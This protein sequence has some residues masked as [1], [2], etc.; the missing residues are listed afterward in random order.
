[1]E[2]ARKPRVSRLQEAVL[3]HETA[4]SLWPGAALLTPVRRPAPPRGG[5]GG[6]AR[7][8][9]ASRLPPVGTQ[10]LVRR[11]FFLARDS[12]PL[13]RHDPARRPRQSPASLLY[14]LEGVGRAVWLL[15]RRPALAQ[16]PVRLLDHGRR[17]P[18]CRGSLW[19]PT[20]G[21]RQPGYRPG[22][23]SRYRPARRR[24]CS[25]ER[26]PGALLLGTTHV[27][28]GRH[29]GGLLQRGLAPGAAFAFPP[30]PLAAVWP[31]GFTPGLYALLRPVD[32]GGPGPFRCRFRAGASGVASHCRLPQSGVLAR[33]A[34]CRPRGGR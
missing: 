5:S 29:P 1:R 26:F 13:F 28:A 9:G 25:P 27:C 30:A 34:R 21:G 10:P 33:P 8:F 31:P 6:G 11:G 22:T 19:P 16:R 7:R 2:P 18:V 24:V 3:V 23:R 32:P 17:L 20:P 12:V 14:P 4:L 15:A